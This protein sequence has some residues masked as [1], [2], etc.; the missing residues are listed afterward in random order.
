[1]THEGD[2]GIKMRY[3]LKL[4]DGTIFPLDEDDPPD[5]LIKMGGVVKRYPLV[6]EDADKGYVYY[7]TTKSEAMTGEYVEHM[8]QASDGTSGL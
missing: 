6:V 7:T 3:L 1:M 5:L 8:V 4:K 2:Y